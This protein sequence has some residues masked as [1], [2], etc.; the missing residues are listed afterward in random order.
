M[1]EPDIQALCDECERQ[2]ESCLYTSAA[3]FEW[4]KS[5]RRLRAVFVVTPVVLGSIAGWRALA[6]DPSMAW[7]VTT[8][9]LLAGLFP[10]IYKALDFDLDLRLLTAH[11]FT[12]KVLQDRFRQ[13]RTAGSLGDPAAFRREF[14]HLMDRMDK[15]REASVTPPERF[16]KRAQRKIAAGDYT[17]SVDSRRKET[18]SQ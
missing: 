10:A 8:C 18:P 15:A 2:E 5:L 7:V 16:F 17:F 14:E 12:F 9:A 3:I 11:G 13:L 4:L 1:V 6:S